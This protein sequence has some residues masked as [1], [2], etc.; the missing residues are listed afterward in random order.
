MWRIAAI[1]LTVFALLQWAWNE[2]RGTRIESLVVDTATVAPAAMLINL[3]TPQVQATARGAKLHAPGGGLNVL[4]GCEGTEIAFLLLAAF[5]AYPMPWRRR[6]IGFALG[7]GVVFSLNIARIL[8]L[9]YAFR[10]Q[11]AWFE[12]LHTLILP[13]VLVAAVALYFHAVIRSGTAKPA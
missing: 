12:P 10:E 11:R 8:V 13:A 2:S 6:L 9:F 7:L 5:C 1:F 4:N 3:I